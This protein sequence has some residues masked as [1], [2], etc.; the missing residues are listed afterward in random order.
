MLQHCVPVTAGLM[1]PLHGRLPDSLTFSADSVMPFEDNTRYLF[2][3]PGQ[4]SIG[5][6][7]F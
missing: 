5:A 6:I 1:A 2:F 4:N 7:N 3:S